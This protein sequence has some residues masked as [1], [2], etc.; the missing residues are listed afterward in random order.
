[1]FR[2]IIAGSRDFDDLKYATQILDKVFSKKV[3]DAIVCGE[4]KG[5]DTVGKAYAHRHQIAVHSFPAAWN[6]HGRSAGYIRNAEMADNA[7]ALVAFWDGESRG[8]KHMINLAR[9]KG[10]KIIVVNYKENKFYK[11]N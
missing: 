5:A 10:L 4:A 1:M 9:E 11:Y 3:P 7:D 6:L 2:V 8:T